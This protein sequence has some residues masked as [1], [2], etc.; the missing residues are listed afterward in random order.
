M[1]GARRRPALGEHRERPLQRPQLE[2]ELGGLC[3]PASM[4]PC[5]SG[6]ST[7]GVRPV[8]F[9]QLGERVRRQGRAGS[10]RGAVACPDF[11]L[12]RDEDDQRARAPELRG[13]DT[14]MNIVRPATICGYSP[15]MRLDPAVNLLTMQALSKGTDHG[16][17]RRPDPARTCTSRTCCACTTIS[18]RTAQ[19]LRG[20]YNAG[21]ENISI[22]D[23]ANRVA[24]AGLQ[25]RSW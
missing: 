17:W 5:R 15:R 9:R 11:R 3:P 12:Q 10:H 25:P 18:L 13:P 7:H 8:Y 19:R 24:K 4:R 6:R 2:A 20:V 23:I 16:L 21:F 14:A 22:L 1:K